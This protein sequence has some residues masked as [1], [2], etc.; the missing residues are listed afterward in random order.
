MAPLGTVLVRWA[1]TA[2]VSDQWIVARDGAGL[3]H[4][5][6]AKPFQSSTTVGP[7]VRGALRGE[8]PRNAPL[9]TRPAACVSPS[10]PGRPPPNTYRISP[11]RGRARG[12]GMEEVRTTKV[13]EEA[14][15][16]RR[17]SGGDGVVC[18]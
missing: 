8:S 18:E 9:H 16:A 4:C 15:A 11:N 2:V 10:Q 13:H 1:R 6:L 3:R 5:S 17:V 12:P 14:G 7:G